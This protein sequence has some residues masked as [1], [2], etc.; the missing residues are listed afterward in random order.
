MIDGRIYYGTNQ[1]LPL[2]PEQR[3]LADLRV[4]MLYNDMRAPLP[5]AEQLVEAKTIRP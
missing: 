4:A 1:Q 3:W 2:T 5:T